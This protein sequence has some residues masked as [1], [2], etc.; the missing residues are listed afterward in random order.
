MYTVG[1][2]WWEPS[3]RASADLRGKTV[4]LDVFGAVRQ[5]TGED[6]EDVKLQLSTARPE[7]GTDVPT[8]LP[9]YIRTAPMAGPAGTGEDE[10]KSE[11]AAGETAEPAPE[12]P[13]SAPAPTEAVSA[14]TA[15]VFVARS[16]ARIPGDGQFHKIP[17]SSLS[18]PVTL[19]HVAIPKILPHAFL[20]ARMTNKAAFPLLPGVVEV[21]VGDSYVGRGMMKTVAPGEPVTLSLG[22]DE[23]I[24]ISIALA[25]TK[26]DRKR[27]NDRVATTNVFN[28]KATNF[29]DEEADLTILDQLPIARSGDVVVTY[30]PAAKNALRGATFPGQLKWEM[31]LAP[32]KSA[33]IEFDF[34]IEYPEAM[35][36][37]LE[38]SNENNTLEY[39]YDSVRPEEAG[40][41]AAPAAP[42]YENKPQK[43]RATVQQLK[44]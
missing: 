19:Q 18:S 42:R 34:T 13:V 39:M 5:Q 27:K 44:F 28:I 7:I 32:R 8:L 17:V 16:A 43:S 25:D 37:A 6:W 30:G 40:S 12:E 1:R 31:K 35:K 2:A 33:E 29:G 41:D 26:G 14:G 11:A 3:Y 20:Q 10:R 9:W 23:T 4:V 36:Q 38:M 24:R 22:V 15:T 21:M